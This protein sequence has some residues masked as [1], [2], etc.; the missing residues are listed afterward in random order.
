MLQIAVHVW[1]V[2]SLAAPGTSSSV[3]LARW[4][5]VSLLRVSFADEI[6]LFFFMVILPGWPELGIGECVPCCRRFRSRKSYR[7]APKHDAPVAAP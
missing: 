2:A 6:F 5:R 1:G 4:R 3:L 7:A